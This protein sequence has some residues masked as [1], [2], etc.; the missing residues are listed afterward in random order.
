MCLQRLD[1]RGMNEPLI[2]KTVKQDT[3]ESASRNALWFIEPQGKMIELSKA[4]AKGSNEGIR[5]AARKA[6]PNVKCPK[7]RKRLENILQEND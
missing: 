3:L 4:L 5:A 7:A 6:L 2:R 1:G